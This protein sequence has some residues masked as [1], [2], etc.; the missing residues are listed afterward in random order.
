MRVGGRAARTQ[1][2]YTLAG[3]ATSTSSTSGRRRCSTALR[4]LPELKD[5]DDRSADRRACS[6]TSRSIATPP[7]A[8]AS[9]RADRRHALRRVRPAPGRD[10]LHADQPV[11]RRARGRSPSSRDGPDALDT[12][13]V[14]SAAT[15]RRSRSRALVA[16]QPRRTPRSRSP[17]RASSRRRRSRSTSRPASSL[18]QAVD[19]IQRGERADRHAREH[20]RA[21]F[22]G[23]AQAFQRLA[24]D[25]AAADPASRCSR[26]TS[27]SACSTRATSTR[28]RSC[29]RCRRRAS[30]RCSRCSLIRTELNL[31]ALDRRSSC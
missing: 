12:L 20:P 23:T 22:Q 31:I 7:R 2:Q 28:S 5:V 1:Y 14:T 24:R 17:T 3:R 8:S 25:A 13:Y 4:K 18:G 9:R 11:P 30:A 15:A 29:R 26:S 16:R 21:S 6:S 27:C 19:A 10:V